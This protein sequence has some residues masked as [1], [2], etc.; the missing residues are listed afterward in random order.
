MVLNDKRTLTSWA[1]TGFVA[2]T[3]LAAAEQLKERWADLIACGMDFLSIVVEDTNND[4][5]DSAKGRTNGQTEAF[6]GS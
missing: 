6:G 4:E 3:V 5:D 1:L 2:T